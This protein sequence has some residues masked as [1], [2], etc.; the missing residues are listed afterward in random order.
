MGYMKTEPT[1]CCDIFVWYVL[2]KKTVTNEPYRF[3]L[4]YPGIKGVF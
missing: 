3:Y 2:S 4:P 1:V